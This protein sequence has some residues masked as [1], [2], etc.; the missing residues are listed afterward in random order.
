MRPFLITGTGRCGTRWLAYSLDKSNGWTIYHEYSND[1]EYLDG[2][3]PPPVWRFKKWYG[4]VNGQL[5]EQ[6]PGMWG[7]GVKFALLVR[8]PKKVIASAATQSGISALAASEKLDKSF[9]TVADIYYSYSDLSFFK[10]F[11]YED[12]FAPSLVVGAE[13]S[14]MEVVKWTGIE[15]L[16]YEDFDFDER[17]GS[18]SGKPYSVDTTDVPVLKGCGFYCDLFGYSTW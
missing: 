17:Y 6:V 8:N 15:D 10:V 16:E 12:I 4:E 1:H 9:Q 5:R 18:S 3:M 7:G 13:S 11:K 14:I 2:D